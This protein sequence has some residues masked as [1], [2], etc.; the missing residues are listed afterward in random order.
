MPPNFNIYKK[1]H[2]MAKSIQRL[3]FKREFEVAFNKWLLWC[4]C[5]LFFGHLH[6]YAKIRCAPRIITAFREAF[7]LKWLVCA[8]NWAS[9]YQENIP[10]SDDSTPNQGDGSSSLMMPWNKRGFQ[11]G[12]GRVRNGPAFLLY[13]LGISAETV[14]KPKKHDFKVYNYLILLH[15]KFGKMYN[16]AF[17]TVLL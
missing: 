5:I 6:K 17:S 4:T 14:E 10:G 16:W 15:V 13:Y 1:N 11:G 9:T 8:I 7:I 12:K 2:V 3:Y